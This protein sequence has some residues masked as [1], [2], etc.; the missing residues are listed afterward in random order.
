M[1]LC[2]AT[3]WKAICHEAGML[4]PVCSFPV[5]NSAFNRLVPIRT[6]TRPCHSVSGATRNKA[7][8][9][10]DK[11]GNSILA[12][13]Y[14]RYCR[15]WPPAPSTCTKFPSGS[16][17]KPRSLHNDRERVLTIAPVSQSAV[18]LLPSRITSTSFAC[19]TS[20][21]NT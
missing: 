16:I 10:A 7:S 9:V 17:S 13:V 20:L 5:N 8:V 12:S 2:L 4:W 18:H 3:L 11:S 15:V 14:P 19:P 1:L 21:S 6:G